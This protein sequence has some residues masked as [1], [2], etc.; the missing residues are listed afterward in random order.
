MKL[1]SAI[2]IALLF[3][4]SL[5]AGRGYQK[6]AVNEPAAQ[7]QVAVSEV[8]DFEKAVE[9]IKKYETL[10]SARHW[11][12]IGYGHKVLPGEK[13]RRGKVLSEKEADALLRKDLLKNCAVFRSFGADSL[14][15][16]VLAYNIG[17]GAALR[18]AVA[19][20]LRAGDR[21]IFDSYVAHSKYRGKTH[22][23]I[24]SRR[25]EEFEQ[26][27]I[28]EEELVAS[29]GQSDS[30]ADD[31]KADDSKAASSQKAAPDS[32]KPSDPISAA[33]YLD[34]ALPENKR[35]QFPEKT[36]YQLA[37]LSKSKRS[38]ILSRSA[39]FT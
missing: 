2:S 35:S 7:Q 24:K 26:L 34:F 23:Q 12:L 36:H 22:K 29:T 10:H 1:F 21:D 8:S 31:S 9:I 33:V 27:F 25:I 5:I 18:S 3:S 4:S 14:L 13:Y 17:S 19:R 28:T 37:C 30:K 6:I 20:K 39:C 15:L 38:Y 16:G 11:P 32:K